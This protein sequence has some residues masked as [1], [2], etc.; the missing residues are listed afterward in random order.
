MVTVVQKKIR[1]LATL[2]CQGSVAT[3]LKYGEFLMMT[4]LLIYHRVSWITVSIRQECNVNLFWTGL[5]HCCDVWWSETRSQW[6]LHPC[7]EQYW[8][9]DFV[10]ARS[11]AYIVPFHRGIHFKNTMMLNSASTSHCGSSVSRNCWMRYIAQPDNIMLALGKYDEGVVLSF[12][13]Y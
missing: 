4:L 10:F 5:V 2:T 11:H 6:L 12:C 8:R 7:Y 3:H 9:N 13:D 1:P